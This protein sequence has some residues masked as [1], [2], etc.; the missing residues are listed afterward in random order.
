MRSG[1]AY[2][3]A[4]HEQAEVSRLDML[5]ADFEAVLHRRSKTCLVAMQALL[6]AFGQPF[7]YVMHRGLLHSVLLLPLLHLVDLLLLRLDDVLSHL[8]QH[9]VLSVLE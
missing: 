8:T 9:R 3:G 7:R 2:L 1:P 6:N 5:T 4:R